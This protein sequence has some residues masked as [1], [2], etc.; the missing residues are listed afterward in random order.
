MFVKK[1]KN[2]KKNKEN[3]QYCCKETFE[4]MFGHLRTKK[5]QLK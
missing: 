2:Q 5:V 3:A 4:S 1:E